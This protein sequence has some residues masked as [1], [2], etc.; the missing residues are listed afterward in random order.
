MICQGCWE[1]AGGGGKG[2]HSCLPYGH[3]E[4]TG[5]GG[6]L[7]LQIGSVSYGLCGIYRSGAVH[8]TRLG[9]VLSAG[10]MGKDKLPLVTGPEVSSTG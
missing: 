5:L 9:V 4:N 3:L 8:L 1:K 7:F 6:S 10:S 2:R